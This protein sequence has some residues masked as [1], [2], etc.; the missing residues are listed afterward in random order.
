MIG[1]RSFIVIDGTVIDKP[2]W[3]GIHRGQAREWVQLLGGTW[4]EDHSRFCESQ[5]YSGNPCDCD[6][7]FR[8]R[9]L[10][11][12]IVREWRRQST[13]SCGAAADLPQQVK[14]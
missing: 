11:G 3:R 13:L 2:N 5:L 12:Q 1:T 6:V 4:E 9:D 10:D 7:V 8:V 14:R